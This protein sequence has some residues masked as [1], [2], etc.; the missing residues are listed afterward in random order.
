MEVSNS[1]K[2]NGFTLI[3]LLVVIAIIAILAAML[4]PALSKAKDRAKAIACTNNNK[5]I[6][7][8]MVMYT[9]DF[10]NILPPLNDKNFAT[11]STNWWF[12]I[13]GSSGNYITSSSV[14]NN[15]WRCP[16]VQNSDI[17]PGTVAYYNS[18]CEGYG[19]L[20]DTI[21]PANG[22]IRYYLDIF[23]NVEN[24]RKYST[25]M[26]PSQI[27]LVGDVGT[28]KSGGNIYQMPAAYNTEI[29]VIKPVINP[30][31]IGWTTVPSY[32]QAAC[33]HNGHAICSFCDGHVESVKWANLVTDINDIF[34]IN[35]F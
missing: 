27:W 30:T 15:V 34:A 26:R 5:Q 32:K 28:P 2:R 10:N 18:P 23:G 14:S 12:R 16:A 8:A 29:T 35:S 11:H 24:G 6:G 25:I 19:P 20:E 1:S 33:R 21:N 13:I 7:L 9:G 4:L 3:E 31:G 22:I 17:P